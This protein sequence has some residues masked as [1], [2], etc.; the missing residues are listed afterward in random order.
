[1]LVSVCL[2]SLRSKGRESE[3]HH[4]TSHGCGHIGCAILEPGSDPALH[5]ALES[6]HALSRNPGGERFYTTNRWN[7]APIG[8]GSEISYSFVPDGTFVPRMFPSDPSNGDTSVLFQRMD[9]LFGD[10]D[11][12]TD[13]TGLWKPLFRQA[14][15]TWERATGNTFVEVPDDGESY[16]AAAGGAGRGDIR[17]SMREIDGVAGLLAYNNFPATGGDLLLDADENWANPFNDFLR[18]RNIVTHELGHAI[19]VLHICPA[20]GDWLMEPFLNLNFDGPQSEDIRGAQSMYGDRFEP[21]D[22]PAEPASLITPN[23]N[24]SDPQLQL[25]TAQTYEDLGTLFSSDNDY[26]EIGVPPGGT[27]SCT[28]TPTGET[29]SQAPQLE[30]GF[31]GIPTQTSSLIV[32]DLAFEILPSGGG[33]PLITVNDAGIAGPESL[34]DFVLEDGGLYLI[35]VFVNSTLR[36]TENEVQLYDMQVLLSDGGIDGDLSGDGC[37]NALDIAELLS[38]W[39]TADLAADLDGNG[40]VGALD[41]AI[42]LGSWGEGCD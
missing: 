9:E 29:F 37:V 41:L 15:D 19:G 33:A 10:G 21:N 6:A 20:G 26:F 34:T 13:D 25:N 24:V 36:G 14:F 18:L 22:T 2:L 12:M 8:E 11:V 1:M 17:I 7:F 27:I 35:R 5:A 32:H 30:T 31:C 39:G 28:I 42:V 3:P 40:D 16:P 4:C 23:P 38:F